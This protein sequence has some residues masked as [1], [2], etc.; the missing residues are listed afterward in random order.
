MFR[1][2]SINQAFGIS[3]MVE[4]PATIDAYIAA[5]PPVTQTALR[6]I[7][8][9]IQRGMPNAQETIAYSIPAYRLNGRLVLYFAGW[10]RHCAVYPVSAPMR[11]ALGE[12]LAPHAAA[13]DS[14][15]FPLGK[16]VPEPL[17]ER[18]AAF[19]AAEGYGA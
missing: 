12:E 11:R 8:A 18:I 15:H 16:P 1:L 6:A 17:I 9:A 5:Q 13:K 4:K 3:V 2:C 14:L 10:K 19:R 7:R